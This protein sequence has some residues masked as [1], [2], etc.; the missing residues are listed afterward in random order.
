MWH[1]DD[2]D[3]DANVFHDN[4]NDLFVN[5]S[6]SSIKVTLVGGWKLPEIKILEYEI[7][8]K[9]EMLLNY[10]YFLF[11]SY[12]KMAFERTTGRSVNM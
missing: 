2:D 10:K 7:R 12:L 4:D 5:M 9:S 11:R 6:I 3:G 1:D 8:I